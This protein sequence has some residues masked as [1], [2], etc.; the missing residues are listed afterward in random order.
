MQVVIN[1]DEYMYERA[2][3]PPIT[4]FYER[5]VGEGTPLSK[6]HGRLIDADELHT[7]SKELYKTVQN[8]SER[9]MGY[10]IA[11]NQLVIDAPTVLEANNE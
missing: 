10:L 3:K 9:K 8:S 4:G 5:V 6:G 11:M 1:I 7:K 2:K